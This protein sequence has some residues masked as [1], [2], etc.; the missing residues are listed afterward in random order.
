VKF[1]DEARIEVI[2][3]DGGDG[4]VAFLREKYRPRGGP[5]G[6]DGGR[7][8]GVWAVA[9]PNLN[10]LLAYR[11]K[12]R[13]KAERG[14]NGRGKSQH[15]RAGADLEL[16]VPPG[17][18]ITDAESGRL[19]ADLTEPGARALVA[20]GG[21]GGRGNARFA[22]ATNQA[23]QRAD[24]GTPGQT[25]VLQLELRLLAD[26]GLVGLP[27]AGKSSLLA[28]VSAARPKVADYPF[29][30]LEPILGVV[31]LDEDR[32]FVLADIPG[33]VE[34]AH[35]GR[36]L[37]LAFLRHIRRTAVLVHLIDASHG[38]AKQALA[39]Y[40]VIAGELR[41]YAEELAERPQ[42]VVISK[43]DLLDTKEALPL[44]RDAF[45]RRNIPLHAVSAVSGEGCRELM[46]EVWSA[47]VRSRRPGDRSA[48]SDDE[49]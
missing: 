42:L 27:N 14:E 13:L 2:A 8:G 20:A 30:T 36:G 4:C 39:D 21:R 19:I 26:A 1:L 47:V 24:P 3:G 23:P 46:S 37:G 44:L 40:D 6:G 35:E 12:R 31:G 34:G 29:T 5:S 16:P 17:T 45:A 7:G 49:S 10:T 9:D 41:A 33:L 43:C 18:I 25:H 11:Y 22:T 38:S 48:V 28:R 32:S 15:G